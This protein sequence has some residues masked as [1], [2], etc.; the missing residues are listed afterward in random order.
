MASAA[1]V[2]L[3]RWWVLVLCM[4]VGAALLV[5]NDLR[6]PD[7]Y[8]ATATLQF[9]TGGTNVSSLLNASASNVSAD[10]QR[11]QNTTLVLITS[12]SVADRVKRALKY[13]GAAGD[14]SAQ[15]V[16]SAQADANLIDVAATDEDPRRAATLANAFAQQYQL[17][18]RD[19]DRA[20]LQGGIEALT[21]Q[22]ARIPESDT[23]QRARLSDSIS[24]LQQVEATTTGGVQVVSAATPPVDRA[25]PRPK[26]DALLGA[27]LGLAVGAVLVF[28]LDL[29]DRRLKTVPQFEEAYGQ[30]V[31]VAI[32]AQAGPPEDDAERQAAVEPFRILRVSLG[33][34][35]DAE[36]AHVVLVT[37]A[38]AA[39]GKTTVA[40]SLARAAAY[41]GQRVVLVELDLRRPTMWWQF[42][43]PRDRRGLLSVL[44][45]EV[46]PEQALIR[47][48][49]DLPTLELLPAGGLPAQSAELLSSSMM[50]WTLDRLAAR[51]D[52]VVLDTPPLLP[53]ADT[54]AL[55][56]AEQIDTCLVVAQA[57]MT[58][59]EQAARAR[60]ILHQHGRDRF[61]LVVN[62]L[63]RN[64]QAYSYR[65]DAPESTAAER[66]RRTPFRM[67]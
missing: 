7:Q 15:I 63:K 39:E 30:G 29:L 11:D 48:Q 3:E 20:G 44:R 54:H 17:F 10:P 49:E 59:A 50:R 22:L 32:P 38:V 33:Q 36:I 57:G 45:G 31:L 64:A 9:G 41:A 34:V 46:S 4:V 61:G 47:P 14:L 25:S 56:D 67:R 51:A 13:P 62:K 42:G 43:L 55:L 16:A 40:A 35:S 53:V 21:A 66:S 37:S 2:L 65:Y 23:T 26:R 18:R 24:A 27:I 5:A 60:T 19:S 12:S 58:T 28:A 8:E 1:R 52:V 6:K